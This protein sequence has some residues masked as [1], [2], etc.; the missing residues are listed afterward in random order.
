ME[1]QLAVGRGAMVMVQ[2]LVVVPA[3]RPVESLT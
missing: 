2:L 3:E 1:T